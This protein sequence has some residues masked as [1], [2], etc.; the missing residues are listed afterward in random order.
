[1][2]NGSVK[3][4][5]QVNV[6]DLGFPHGKTLSDPELTTYAD[7]YLLE[8]L[9][10]IERRRT[11]Y[12]AS[13]VAHIRLAGMPAARATWGGAVGGR[14]VVGVM[15]SVIVRNRYAV[16]LHTQD[17]GREPT[18]GMFEAMRSIESLTLADEPD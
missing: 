16:I 8:Y 11:G 9:G 3:T 17:L 1:M 6:L 4:L 5:L 12:S 18:A 10:G 7:R 13:P 15:Y 14:D 2:R